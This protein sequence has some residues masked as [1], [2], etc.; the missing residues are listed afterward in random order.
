MVDAG[1]DEELRILLHKVSRRIRANRANEKLSDTHMGVLFQLL[2][3]DR[4]LGELAE[5]E[6]VSPPSMNRTINTLEAAGLVQRTPSAH[7]ARKVSIHI[8]E[9]GRQHLE[10]TRR[11][12]AMWF[13]EQLAAFTDDERRALRDVV[14]LLRRLAES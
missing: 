13:S 5:R 11:L 2:Q 1:D 14:P 12:R 7:D 6:R 9:A 8:T 4:S 3:A 10:E